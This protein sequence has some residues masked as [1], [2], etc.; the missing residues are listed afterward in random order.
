MLGRA[1][2][3]K[4]ALSQENTTIE[5]LE[6]QVIA[7]RLLGRLLKPRPKIVMPLTTTHP[8]LRSAWTIVAIV[9]G[10]QYVV[11]GK[12]VDLVWHSLKGPMARF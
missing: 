2:G 7:L 9:V 12:S 11:D 6:A 3:V 10:P 4:V 1:D 5:N 8:A